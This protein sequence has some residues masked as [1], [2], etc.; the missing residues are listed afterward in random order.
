MKTVELLSILG[1]SIAAIAW[2]GLMIEKRLLRRLRKVGAVDPTTAIPVERQNILV[3][4][5][6]QQLVRSGVLTATNPS[7][8]YFDE[9]SYSLLRTR[10]RKRALTVVGSILVLLLTYFLIVI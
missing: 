9:S 8:Y 7:T 1:W 2:M 3:R 5:R 10:R 4:W 6:I